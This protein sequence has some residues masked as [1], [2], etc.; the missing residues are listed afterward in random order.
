MVNRFGDESFL[1]QPG[2]S[3]KMQAG[4]Q[5]GLGLVQ[6][7]AQQ[8]G[9]EVVIAVPDAL[10]IQGHQEEIFP[11]QVFEDLL[12]DGMYSGNAR[13]KKP[14]PHAQPGC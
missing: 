5:I 8:I 9:K 2:G 10:I 14:L 3:P 7:G 1:L 11:F 6:T 4:D 13:A 12:A